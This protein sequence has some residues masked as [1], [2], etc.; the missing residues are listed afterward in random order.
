MKSLEGMCAPVQV[1]TV[2]AIISTVLY[3]INMFTNVHTKDPV[4]P[5]SYL[6]KNNAVQYGYMALVLKVVFYI[7]FG[8]LLQV[9]CKNRLDKVAWIIL[10]LPYVLFAFIVVFGMSMSALAVVRGNTGLLAGSGFK[11]GGSAHTG[12]IHT[13]E[14][15]RRAHGHQA[16]R[17]PFK[18]GG[19]AHT[20]STHGAHRA[21]HPAVQEP[22]KVGGQPMMPWQRQEERYNKCVNTGG[23]PKECRSKYQR[24]R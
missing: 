1:F 13:A 23:D 9:L 5:G 21:K 8:Y 20:G 11:V 10:F 16:V 3:L 14:G 17:Q 19:A 24:I 12:S 22:F 15:R 6:L 18:V 4:D 7:M 2:L